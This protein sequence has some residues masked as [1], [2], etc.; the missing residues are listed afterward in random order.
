MGTSTIRMDLL[1]PGG[2]RVPANLV[3]EQTYDTIDLGPNAVEPDPDWVFTDPAGHEHSYARTRGTNLWGRPRL[4]CLT[5]HTV[6]TATWWCADC[7][8][9]HEDREVRCVSC[10]AP[11]TPGMMPAP[12]AAGMLMDESYRVEVDNAP[13]ALFMVAGRVL[14]NDYLGEP[15]QVELVGES[16][17]MHARVVASGRMRVENVQSSSEGVTG[18]VVYQLDGKPTITVAAPTG[19]RR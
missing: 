16:G 15:R 5:V 12:S 7:R 14:V 9:E 10:D 3:F 6:V 1:L 8:D 19:G 18:R 2:D 4:D 13:S 17:G 11:V